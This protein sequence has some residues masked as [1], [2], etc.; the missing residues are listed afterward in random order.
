VPPKDVTVNGAQSTRT[1]MA[2]SR[3]I[4]PFPERMFTV[5]PWAYATGLSTP[6]TTLTGVVTYRLNGPYD[7]DT[8]VGGGQP[9][10]YDQLTP[11]YDQYRVVRADVEILFSDPSAIYYQCG[12]R[13]RRN[14]DTTTAGLTY[15]QAVDLPLTR[16]EHLSTTG[17]R[18][19]IFKF[20]V[21]PAKVFGMTDSQLRDDPN[22]ASAANSTPTNQVVVDLV[23]LNTAAA[24][25]DAS[26]KIRVQYHTEW[27]KLKLFNDA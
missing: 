20:S 1:V 23:A 24:A 11:I 13:V 22:F 25:I 9:R 14:A 6:A 19:R 18:Q 4:S 7:P 15:G 12:Y 5:L 27:S 3:G 17:S 8:G 21:N 26:V 10:G 16:L 2:I